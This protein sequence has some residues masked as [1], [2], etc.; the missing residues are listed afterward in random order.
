LARSSARREQIEVQE[1][2]RKGGGTDAREIAL[3]K[4]GIPTIVCGVGVRYAHSHNSLISLCDY[5]NLVKLLFAI[6]QDMTNLE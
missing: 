1:A 5:R 2:V 6:S 3:A 4:G